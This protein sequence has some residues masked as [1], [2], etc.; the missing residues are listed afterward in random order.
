MPTFDFRCPNSLCPSPRKF[1]TL[2]KHWD[3][4]DPACPRC[5]APLERQVPAPKAI[6]T[7]PWSEY[8]FREGDQKNPNWSKEGTYVYRTR[9]SRLPDGAPERVLL[10]NR[11]DVKEYC[12]A[13]GLN[14]PDDLNPN[15]RISED[16]KTLHTCGEPG[17][18]I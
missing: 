3:D 9:S 11:Q 15:A 18:W 10:R 13:E 1:E 5:G 16:G 12:K 7:K 14:L 2:L 4:P 17:Q 6:W 8:G